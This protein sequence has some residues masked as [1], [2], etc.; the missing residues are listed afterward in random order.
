MAL[1]AYEQ[2]FALKEYNSSCPV[3]EKYYPGVNAASLALLV[4]DVAKARHLAQRVTDICADPGALEK[5]DSFWL[6]ATEGEAALILGKYKEA[7]VFY[8]QALTVSDAQL[9]HVQSAYHQI[10]RLWHVLDKNEV[11]RIVD[12]LF[13][14]HETWP[15]VQAGP[16]GGCGGRK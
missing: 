1:A 16:I 15:R 12:E 14:R 13:A 4:H 9:Q 5:G 10:C 2:A 8:Q 7:Y 11:G 3:S 6:Y